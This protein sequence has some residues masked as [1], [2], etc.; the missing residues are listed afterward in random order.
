MIDLKFWDTVNTTEIDGVGS[1]RFQI[2]VC[3]IVNF[4]AVIRSQEI[5]VRSTCSSMGTDCLT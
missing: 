3:S 4:G 2:M 5:V 1:N